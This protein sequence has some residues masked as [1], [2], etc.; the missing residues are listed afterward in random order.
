MENFFKIINNSDMELSEKMDLTDKLTDIILLDSNGKIEEFAALGERNN[1]KIIVDSLNK[2]CM[3]KRLGF[4]RLP[5]PAA[6][7]QI[8]S[9][10]RTIIAKAIFKMIDGSIMEILQ[11]V[12]EIQ[13]QKCGKGELVADFTPRIDRPYINFR[14]E[15][16]YSEIEN[17]YL[18]VDHI[19]IKSIN[20]VKTFIPFRLYIQMKF[21]EAYYH[22]IEC[23]IT[24][25]L[26]ESI[27]NS[28]GY[29][30]KLKDREDQIEMENLRK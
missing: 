24:D 12:Y 27:K 8:N 16:D 23:E 25:E 13:L 21:F 11:K 2:I 14:W 20:K 30:E 26:I 18:L 19:T 15:N 17:G 10:L 3:E 28:A 29:L 1:Q 5:I 7:I 22:K 9:D 4:W 6:F